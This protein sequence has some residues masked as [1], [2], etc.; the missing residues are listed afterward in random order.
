MKFSKADI[1]KI[2]AMMNSEKVEKDEWIIENGKIVYGS[3]HYPFRLLFLCVS[4]K[5]KIII[6][7]F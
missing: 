3:F 7:L 4:F 6:T 5:S 1:E 2:Q